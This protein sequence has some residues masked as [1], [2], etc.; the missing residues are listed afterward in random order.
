MIL[1]V[2]IVI[3]YVYKNASR[4]GNDN[5]ASSGDSNDGKQRYYKYY[6]CLSQTAGN[7]ID[8]EWLIN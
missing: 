6:N 7:S 8:G 3:I 1:I 5:H 2:M 4:K